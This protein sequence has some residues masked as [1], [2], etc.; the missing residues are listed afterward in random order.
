MPFCIEVT[1]LDLVA[2]SKSC[3]TLMPPCLCRR[4]YGSLFFR[5]VPKSKTWGCAAAAAAST[6]PSRDP[7]FASSRHQCHVAV[8]YEGVQHSRR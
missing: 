2:L 3:L 5:F 4:L 6:A 8:I 7:E 1:M